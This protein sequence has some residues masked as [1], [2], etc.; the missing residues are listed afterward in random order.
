M[1]DRGSLT[2]KVHMSPTVIESD[3]AWARMRTAERSRRELK[4]CNRLR[5]IT[6]QGKGPDRTTTQEDQSPMDEARKK[7]RWWKAR[8][9]NSLGEM[10]IARAEHLRAVRMEQGGRPSVPMSEPGVGSRARNALKLEGLVSCCKRGRVGNFQLFADATQEDDYMSADVAVMSMMP[11]IAEGINA[12]GEMQ[13]ASPSWVTNELQPRMAAANMSMEG[14]EMQDI[15]SRS[16][17]KDPSEEEEREG[18]RAVGMGT[19]WKT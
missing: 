6:T 11:C 5:C 2:P 16:V 3:A 4:S 18:I 1:H 17:H 12:S 13:H 7:R 8:R 19:W 10:G 14:N 15:R 9:T